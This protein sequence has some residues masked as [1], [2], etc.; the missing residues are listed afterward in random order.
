MNTNTAEAKTSTN[1]IR[2]STGNCQGNIKKVK[3][4]DLTKNE[5]SNIEKYIKSLSPKE[6]A[7]LYN[8]YKIVEHYP[9][10]DKEN[11]QECILVSNTPLGKYN[12]SSFRLKQ[13]TNKYI[14]YLKWLEDNK[15]IANKVKGNRTEGMGYC[16][17]PNTKYFNSIFNKEFKKKSFNEA[18]DFIKN[19]LESVHLRTNKIGKFYFDL[20]DSDWNCLT[21]SNK[22]NQQQFDDQLNYWKSIVD[23]FNNK[24]IKGS[25]SST[26]RIFTDVIELPKVIRNKMKH[27]T[28]TVV[29]VD[30]NATI[31]YLLGVVVK[32]HILTKIKYEEYRIDKLHQG[33]YKKVYRTF[34]NL[35][36]SHKEYTI[37]ILNEI[38][39]YNEVVTKPGDTYINLLNHFDLDNYNRDTFKA[40]LLKSIF[41]IDNGFVDDRTDVK[42]A[43]IEAFPLLYRLM[44]YDNKERKFNKDKKRFHLIKASLTNKIFNL[45]SRIIKKAIAILKKTTRERTFLTIHDAL[46]VGK[47]CMYKLEESLNVAFNDLS[48]LDAK[49]TT[50]EL[51]KETTKETITTTKE[52]IEELIKELKI[53]LY[54]KD[55]KE[56]YIKT[57]TFY[58]K[59]LYK[60]KIKSSNEKEIL[61][62]LIEI[63]ELKIETKK[64]KIRN[65]LE[66]N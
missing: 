43:F 53:G 65:K 51:S 1:I 10:V 17:L 16:T 14:S 7:L 13:Q 50:K 66:K 38:E 29:E 39:K 36:K 20:K 24:Q 23:K 18:R 31:P 58:G 3:P 44:N 12:I 11:N 27:K 32:K 22:Q 49:T 60:R 34:L 52:S 8:I 42:D 4:W 56:Y 55:G 33:I 15:F 40:T 47:D 48:G 59:K 28:S 63:K 64:I 37:N 41:D 61:D 35:D 25:I 26:G 54:T 6:K 46:L 45:E 2:T 5:K 21:K 30:I 9:R 62:W 19:R 57:I